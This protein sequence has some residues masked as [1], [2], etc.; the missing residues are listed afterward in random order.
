MPDLV[1]NIKTTPGLFKHDAVTAECDPKAKISK[2][3]DRKEYIY[4]KANMVQIRKDLEKFRESVIKQQETNQDVE[5]N[6]NSFKENIMEILE[7]NIP[8]KILRGGKIDLPWMTHKMQKMM[9]SRQKRY[10]KAKKSG[11]TVYWDAYRAI[12]KTIK[13]E[14]KI[15]HD[16]Y[17]MILLDESQ[18]GETKKIFTYVKA[19]RRDMVGVSGLEYN[20]ELATTGKA[21]ADVLSHQYEQIFT[22]E[23]SNHMSTMGDNPYIS[24]PYIVIVVA[25]VEKLLKILNPKKAIG[26]D[27]LPN[28]MLK[29]NADLV[30]SILTKIFQHPLDTG[31]VPSDWT[32]ANV[33]AIFK[34]GKRSIP[35]NYRPVSLTSMICKVQEHN[36][37]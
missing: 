17:L 5:T 6:W 26:P 18:G 31:R 35:V 2:T 37:Q 34:K 32:K 21:K 22:K 33:I 4:R 27:L 3:K 12:Q 10:T 15:S 7:K 25:G 24:M 14:I 36:V 11:K 16:R 23:D 19:G 30:A 8:S 29:E 28:R 1:S 20:G 13:K 9:K